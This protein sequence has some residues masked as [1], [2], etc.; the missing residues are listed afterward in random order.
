MRIGLHVMPNRRRSTTRSAVMVTA[1]SVKSWTWAVNS[2][3]SRCPA[4]SRVPLQTSAPPSRGYASVTVRTTIGWFSIS[5]KSAERRWLSRCLFFVVREVASNDTLMDD[6]RD[7]DSRV[8][9]GE[10]SHPLACPGRI[11]NCDGNAHYARPHEDVHWPLKT[12]VRPWRRAALSLLTCLGVPKVHGGR[13]HPH[14]GCKSV[15]YLT[16]A[17]VHLAHQPR[18]RHS[19]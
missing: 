5:K 12:A 7:T 10:H 2:I 4:A 16:Y 17:A 11:P 14:M 1:R 13:Y 8:P 3:G 6:Q 18:S 9:P 19:R 15:A